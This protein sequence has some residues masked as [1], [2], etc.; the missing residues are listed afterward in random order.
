MGLAGITLSLYLLYL[1]LII[2]TYKNICK[3][4]KVTSL[5]ICSN[6]VYSPTG[7]YRK[8]N[9]LK[10]ILRDPKERKQIIKIYSTGPC[11]R[12]IYSI[13]I[14]RKGPYFSKKCRVKIYYTGPCYSQNTELKYILK[15][16][17]EYFLEDITVNKQNLNI[18]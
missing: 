17:T 15:D 2:Y 12:K 8:K 10:Y 4:N 3:D 18:F 6:S 14:Y 11:Y 7:S 16:P 9:K 1:L 13:K 5:A